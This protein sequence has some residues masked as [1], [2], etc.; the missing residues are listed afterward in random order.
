MPPPPP[1]AVLLAVIIVVVVS[2][3]DVT[4]TAVELN[5]QLRHD[6]SHGKPPLH[7]RPLAD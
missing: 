6:R 2:E 5:R 4:F 3:Y 1:T 7:V